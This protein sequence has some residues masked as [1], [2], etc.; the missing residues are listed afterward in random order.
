MYTMKINRYNNGTKYL[1]SSHLCLL[2]NKSGFDI[3]VADIQRKD[4]VLFPLIWIVIM[5]LRPNNS[6]WVGGC[7]WWVVDGCSWW[8]GWCVCLN[9]DGLAGAT[10]GIHY[11]N[12]LHAKQTVFWI[13]HLKYNTYRMPFTSSVVLDWSYY[14]F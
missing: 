13:Q 1:F 8:V 6:G 5:V 10:V 11:I 12:T 2:C 4:L 7:V 3:Y 9:V 14:M